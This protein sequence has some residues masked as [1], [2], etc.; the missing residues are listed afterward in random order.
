M[1]IIRQIALYF[2]ASVMLVAVCAGIMFNRIHALNVAHQRM[3]QEWK[4]MRILGRFLDDVENL[5]GLISA[6]ENQS[7][8]SDITVAGLKNLVPALEDLR[9]ESVRPESFEEQSHMMV[10][11]KD[12]ISIQ[13][14]FMSFVSET[15]LMQLKSG[16]IA[17]EARSDILKELELL[18]KSAGDLQDFYIDQVEAASAYAQRA[19]QQIFYQIIIVLVVFLLLLAFVTSWFIQLVKKSTESMIKHEQGMTIGLLAQSLAHEIR[20]PLGIICVSASAICEKFSKESEERELIGGIVTEAKRIGSLLEQL[21]VLSRSQKELVSCDPTQIIKDVVGLMAPL[22]EKKKV[23]M[24]FRDQADVKEVLWDKNQIKQMLINILL[25]SIDAATG[26]TIE[27]VSISKGGWY[28]LTV[29]D[30]G[31]GFTPHAREHAFEPFFSTKNAGTGLG[32]FVAKNIVESHRGRLTIDP[33][34]SSGAR[35]EVFLPLTETA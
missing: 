24:S 5:I 32:L 26:G 16:P 6:D 18:K 33:H 29:A 3:A 23:Q 4:E 10:E 9:E 12:F 17:V 25:N 7:R 8:L 2:A 27:I 28:H 15:Q 34:F 11:R 21:L 35:L 19:R 20:N 22:C 13:Q 1:K 30:N 31:S 14:Q